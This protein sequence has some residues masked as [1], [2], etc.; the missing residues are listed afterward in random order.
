MG[1]VASTEYLVRRDYAGR[2]K[3]T[4]ATGE[5]DDIAMAVDRR[6]AKLLPLIDRV[7]SRMPE[8]RAQGIANTWLRSPIDPTW[9]FSYDACSV[10]LARPGSTT[11]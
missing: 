3:V 9:F 10:P 2:L 7:L 6:Y 4:A 5:R 1:D 11:K 8:R